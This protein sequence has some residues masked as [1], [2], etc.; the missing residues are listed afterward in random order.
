MVT[1]TLE[2][3]LTNLQVELLR[4]YSANLTDEELLEV[5][6]LLAKYLMKRARIRAG[7]IWEERGY[8]EETVR[9]WLNKDYS[10]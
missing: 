7:E 6:D 2:K 10:K 3:P 5:R 1:L 8:N 9:K 4:F